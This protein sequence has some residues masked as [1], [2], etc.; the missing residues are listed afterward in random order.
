MTD[1]TIESD[2]SEFQFTDDH[3]VYWDDYPQA[4]YSKTKL[5]AMGALWRT[6]R[7][8]QRRPRT[9][10]ERLCDVVVAARFDGSPDW[11]AAPNGSNGS[12]PRASTPPA[13]GWKCCSILAP[14]RR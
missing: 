5:S 11:A 4:K 10:V 9:G 1:F 3:Y 6:L 7:W 12:T 13:S 14:S 2:N 8:R